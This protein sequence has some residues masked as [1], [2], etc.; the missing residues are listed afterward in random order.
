MYGFSSGGK[1]MFLKITV[2]IPKLVA[3]T[4]RLMYQGFKT[5]T[6]PEH[7]YNAFESFIDFEIRYDACG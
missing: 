3:T 2:A 1:S 7:S 5:P 6:Y 4:K